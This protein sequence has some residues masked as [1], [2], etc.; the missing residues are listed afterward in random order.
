MS[1][2]ALVRGRASSL[3][4]YGASVVLNG[5]ISLITI[6]VIVAIAGAGPWAS[7]AT[8]Q[9]I[10]GS[11]GVLVAFG[12]GLTGP[13]TIAMTAPD[14]RPALFLDSLFARGALLIPLL[15][16]EAVV[17]MA[18]VPNAKVV[19]FAAGLSM[20]LAGASAN[21]YFTGE[22]RPGRFLVLDTVPRVGGTILGLLLVLATHE[23]L[24]FA[25][26]QLAGSLVALI[27]SAVVILRR[28][29]LDFRAASRWS[30]I[31]ESLAE[32]RHGVVATGLYAA[33]T[34]AVLAIVALA[35][36]TVLPLFVLADR[37]SKFVG[38]AVSPLTQVFQG[39]VP[40][41]FGAEL[42]RRLRVSGTVTVVTALV[43]GTLYAA[44]LPWFAT[45]LT[46]GQVVFDAVTAI[47]FGL[48]AAIQVV[49]P[50][51]T[52]VAL[53]AVGRLRVI[54]LSASVGVPLS[55]A[56]LVFVV[57]ARGGEYSAWALV[58]GNLVILAWQVIAL[59]ETLARLGAVVGGDAAIVP[60]QRIRVPA[61]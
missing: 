24:F 36:P 5:A 57:W 48:I 58:G 35:A 32:Q 9:S 33:F 51:L 42:V 40:S 2:V 29:E 60:V 18:I 7:M 21:W 30:A 56:A 17:T 41:V 59:R 27:A 54:A 13:A 52:N 39:W 22:S 53:M 20:T 11:F 12:W 15:L 16:I 6:P 47:A 46:H 31:V 26:A 4:L 28:R 23:L 10:G 45:L 44:L 19:A 55:L 25:L 3:G 61:P 38:M 49:L 50:F 37:L 8:G 14:R 1:L 43:A 34:P